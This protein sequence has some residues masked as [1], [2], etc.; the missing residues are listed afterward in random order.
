MTTPS[1]YFSTRE[2]K[3]E[4]RRDQKNFFS[5]S[6]K[7]EKINFSRFVWLFFLLLS[8]D[9]D[10]EENFVHFVFFPDED[11]ASLLV[12][13]KQKSRYRFSCRAE[14]ERFK[15]AEESSEPTL[16]VGLYCIVYIFF[17]LLLSF[18][19]SFSGCVRCIMCPCR[20]SYVRRPTVASFLP[21]SLTHGLSFGVSE[22]N[23]RLS[24]GWYIRNVGNV[25]RKER[26]KE[27]K[28][29]QQPQLTD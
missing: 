10:E 4:K 18:F 6:R 23:R 16:S 9:E 2:K 13:G 11:E 14:A 7:E 28:K 21:H 19:R 29:A 8:L 25:R 12:L 15:K 3:K 20:R 24:N 27:R 5:R 17:R 26:K 22:R 1:I